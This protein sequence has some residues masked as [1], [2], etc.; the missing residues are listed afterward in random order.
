MPRL[1]DALSFP[2]TALL[3]FVKLLANAYGLLLVVIFMSYGLVDIPRRLWFKGSHKFQVR[4]VR[5]KVPSYREDYEEAE[6]NLRDVYRVRGG[7]LQ[8]WTGQGWHAWLTWSTGDACVH[9]HAGDQL[10]GAE[11]GGAQQAS[12]VARH[13]HCQGKGVGSAGA[14]VV[15]WPG[16]GRGRRVGW[17]CAGWRWGAIDRFYPQ[18]CPCPVLARLGPTWPVLARLVPSCPWLS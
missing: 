4:Y 6:D 8:G 1:L 5:F 2:R 11:S 15:G 7:N 18:P 9:G 12:Q 3:D 10:G 14:G 16:A 13:D 17:A